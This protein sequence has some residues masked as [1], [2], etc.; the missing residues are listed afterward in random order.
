MTSHLFLASTPFN[1]LTAS[2]VALSLPKSDKKI[3]ALIDQP[4]E[5][6]EFVQSILD[7]KAS[8][9]FHA[10][11]SSNQAK[12]KEK[13]K[14]RNQAFN[15]IKSLIGTYTPDLIY[16]GNDR[17]IEFQYAMHM[18]KDNTQG[19]YID[20][21]TYSYLGRKT[22]WLK[23]KVIDNF[24]KK[25]TYG[26]WWKQPGTIGSSDW[27]SKSILAFPDSAYYLLKEKPI[28]ALPQNLTDPAFSELTNNMLDTFRL[29]KSDIS[30][31]KSLALLPHDSVFDQSF[32]TVL[33][34][35]I[36]IDS[37]ALA[38]KHHPRT[39]NKN[40]F[41][42]KDTKELPSK[43]PM[44]ILLPSLDKQCKI[45]GDISTALLTS[46]WLRPELNCCALLKQK[47]SKGS[48]SIN[49][50]WLK[51]LKLLDIEIKYVA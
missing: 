30:E 18:S 48:H 28:E 10:E 21:G 40:L 38:I 44:E 36:N 16:T 8:P 29:N 12:G 26:D 50:E 37:K 42:T 17:R 39:Q 7:W 14:I 34:D 24:I 2:M 3:L 23:D 45:Y 31:L 4:K 11:I 5:T 41:F 27:I 47:D 22:H 51:L 33:K 13:T 25:L 32:N 49:S 1:M 15:N 6:S 19:I 46:K 9:F 43:I 20:D 35:L